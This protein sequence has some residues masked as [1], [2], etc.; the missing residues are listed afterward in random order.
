[1]AE[2]HLRS[3][4]LT[5]QIPTALARLIGL[6]TLDLSSNSL[7]GELPSEFTLLEGLEALNIAHNHLDGCIPADLEGRVV[8]GPSATYGLWFCEAPSQ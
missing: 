4:R 8:F 2:L 5:G 7:T 1:M 3:R 6:A